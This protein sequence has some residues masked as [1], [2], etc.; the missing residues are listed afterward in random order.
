M[1]ASLFLVTY[2]TKFT[3]KTNVACDCGEFS[4]ADT[5]THGLYD[6]VKK[7]VRTASKLIARPAKDLI[8]FVANYFG[9]FIHIKLY[10]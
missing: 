3:Q 8:N 1:C 5:H 2:L 10:D 4:D 7:F 6:A 9:F